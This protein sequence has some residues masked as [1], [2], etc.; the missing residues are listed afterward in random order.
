MYWRITIQTLNQSAWFLVHVYV[1]SPYYSDALTCVTYSQ[2]DTLNVP[3]VPCHWIPKQVDDRPLW[4]HTMPDRRVIFEIVLLVKFVIFLGISNLFFITPNGDLF[5]NAGHPV[6][7]NGKFLWGCLCSLTWGP[8]TWR[9]A[10]KEDCQSALWKATRP[11]YWIGS[12]MSHVET[13]C[14]L[15]NHHIS[16]SSHPFSVCSCR[17]TCL[18]QAHT[19][20]DPSCTIFAAASNHLSYRVL[21]TP[22]FSMQSMVV[23]MYSRCFCDPPSSILMLMCNSHCVRY[24][25]PCNLCIFRLCLVERQCVKSLLLHLTHIW[26]VPHPRNGPSLATYEPVYIS[27]RY[28]RPLAL[29]LRFK[30]MLTLQTFLYFSSSCSLIVF[31]SKGLGGALQNMATHG[32][33]CNARFATTK[34]SQNSARLYP[35]TNSL[36]ISLSSL[37]IMYSTHYTPAN[38]L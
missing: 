6:T 4:G 27:R 8:P 21:K 16:D 29:L 23:S 17:R 33:C 37:N 3:G 22:P 26:R 35:C 14:I 18:F 20:L 24:Q 12:H 7:D 19:S 10:V 28:Q 25:R 34:V 15:Q 13:A 36:R 9:E 31:W 30:S 5:L 2:T 11:V 32:C 1:K 38:H